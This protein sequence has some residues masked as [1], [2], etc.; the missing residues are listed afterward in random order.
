VTF[1]SV[2]LMSV[3]FLVY[4]IGGQFLLAKLLRWFPLAGFQEGFGGLRFV[5]LPALIGIFAG[6]GGNVRFYRTVML[7]EMNRDYVRTAL[8]KGVAGSRILFVHVLKN[9]AVPILTSFVLALPFVVTGNLLL[10]SFFGIPGIGT[11]MVDA[12]NGQDFAVIRALVFLGTI[13]YILGAI[14]TDLS[15][16]LVDPRVRLE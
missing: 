1:L 11:Y 9:A 16:A 13:L 8:A 12:I 3:T 6:L 5:M 2:L 4:I 15:Y 14:L 10:E 7:D